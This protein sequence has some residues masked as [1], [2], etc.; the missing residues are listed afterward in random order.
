MPK[1]QVITMMEARKTRAIFSRSRRYLALSVEKLSENYLT[2][3]RQHV[4]KHIS[5]KNPFTRRKKKNFVLM[6][7]GQK[8]YFKSR[9]FIAKVKSV[10]R[11]IYFGLSWNYYFFL[12]E[13]IA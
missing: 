6:E 7:C 1:L 10:S 12:R 13:R 3:I 4:V 2:A 9:S 11:R 5:L 8:F